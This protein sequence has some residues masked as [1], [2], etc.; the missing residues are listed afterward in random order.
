MGPLASTEF[1][2]TIC[3]LSLAHA[4]TEQDMSRVILVSDPDIPDRTAAITKLR[5][6]R[7]QQYEDVKK[8][9]KQLLEMLG[10]MPVDRIFIPCVTAH[11]FLPYL[12]LSS[13]V[14]SR[15]CSLISTVRDALSAA[16]GK[17]ILLRTNGTQSAKIFENHP[18]WHEVGSRIMPIDDV[19]QEMIHSKYLYK[20]KKEDVSPEGLGMLKNLIQKY[21]AQGF[22]AGCT[23]VHLQTAQL[24]ANDI[25][26]IDPLQIIARE[27]ASK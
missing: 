22:V 25:R 13:A 23:E 19:D 8:R 6:G 12:D 1:L 3:R 15:I 14:S 20:I 10:T 17:Y 7:P 26:V 2:R 5:E 16:E 11:F 4:E 24:I 27:I 18:G 21:G 9:L